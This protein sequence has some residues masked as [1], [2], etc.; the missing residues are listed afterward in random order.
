[1]KINSLEIFI[2]GNPTPK[3]GGRYFIFV[4][5]I[6]NDGIEG[7]GEIYA[8]TFSP[9]V[10]AKMIEDIFDRHVQGWNPYN[11]ELL[12]RIIY[13]RGYTLRPDL[14]LVG[15]LSGIEMACWDIIGKASNRPIYD[16]LGG[17]VREKLR[18]YTYL[19]PET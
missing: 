17:R 10:V 4:K 5:L 7:I 12:W 1:M 6:T 19:Y 13:G 2:V 15:V 14:S 8:S 18:T 9:K 16:L 3:F 11:I